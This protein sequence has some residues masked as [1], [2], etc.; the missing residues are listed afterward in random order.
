[1]ILEKNN[2][3]TV[4]EWTKSYI[5][6]IALYVHRINSNHLRSHQITLQNSTKQN[7]TMLTNREWVSSRRITSILQLVTVIGQKS[8]VAWCTQKWL[9]YF[10]WSGETKQPNLKICWVRVDKEGLSRHA[11]CLTVCEKTRSHHETQPRIRGKRA[12][13][14]PW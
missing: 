1:M 12:V 7:E 8:P 3:Q 11:H 4:Q 2:L 14:L 10:K 13:K 5:E 6:L 9:H